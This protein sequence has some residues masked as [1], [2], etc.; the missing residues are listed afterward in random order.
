M[1]P[2]AESS[3]GRL[4]PPTPPP[5]TPHSH[6]PCKLRCDIHAVHCACLGLH[7]CML[8]QGG[9]PSSPLTLRPAGAGELSGTLSCAP[10]AWC[11]HP[12]DTRTGRGWV[13]RQNQTQ[14][15]EIKS[16]RWFGPCLWRPR[17]QLVTP[18]WWGQ[19]LL[20]GRAPPTPVHPPPLLL[21]YALAGRRGRGE[22]PTPYPLP[23]PRS[24]CGLLAALAPDAHA[25]FS[26]LACLH[27]SPDGR[28]DVSPL[29]NCTQQSAL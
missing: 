23:G 8:G 21:R 17:G 20:P 29:W 14:K 13:Q 25:A 6:R 5:P 27:L 22:H 16:N 19:L 7:A 3:A 26:P 9:P 18:S 15:S 2:K 12:S 11:A 1:R 4:V 10:G 24:A 28:T